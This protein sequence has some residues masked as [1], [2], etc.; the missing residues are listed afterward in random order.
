MS[1]LQASG[2]ARSSIATTRPAGQR[3][4][5]NFSRAS[6]AFAEVLI[7]SITGSMLAKATI[8]PSSTCPRS[9]AFRN[10]NKV[11]RVTTSRRW[12]T[13]ASSIC[14]RFKVRGWPSTKAT[15]LMPNTFSICVCVYRLL[16]RTSGTSP[17]RSSITI[18]IP[19]LSDSSRSSV[20]PSIFLSLTSSAIFS[21]KR[22]LLT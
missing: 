10:S 9:R 12:R 18:R 2:P 22:A 6:A 20:M 19:S 8:N 1:G 13:K 3:C 17:R 14:L 16:I 11:R 21:I 7:S 4:A 5:T 15:T